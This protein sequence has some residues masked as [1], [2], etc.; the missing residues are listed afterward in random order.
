MLLHQIASR[1]GWTKGHTW[2]LML[3]ADDATSKVHCGFF[4]EERGIWSVLAGIQ[5]ILKRGL[6]DCFGLCP[7]LPKRL[8]A[9][10]T[11]FGGRTRPQLDR[12][13]SELGIE[14]V[15]PERSTQMRNARMVATLHN[16]LPQELAREGIA[17]IERANV[18]LTQFWVEFNESF[19]VKPREPSDAFV[20]LEPDF[21]ARV[22]EQVFCLKH[23][24]RVSVRN[25][26]HCEGRELDITR[27]GCTSPCSGDQYWIHEYEDGRC[28]LFDRYDRVAALNVN[29]VG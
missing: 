3:L 19:T 4:V 14:V 27:L 24:A 28:V 5:T 12:V 23:R 17:D 18:Y 25:R 22:M 10:E 15:R 20:A 16:R 26:L 29:G 1:H 13:M 21:L 7:E 2:D 9:Q 11:A 6:F 8:S